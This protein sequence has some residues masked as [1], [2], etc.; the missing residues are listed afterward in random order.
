MPNSS[1]Y[2][3]VNGDLIEA[4][5]FDMWAG[6][7]S[8]RR[9]HF[10]CGNDSS[11]ALNAVPSVGSPR[12]LKHSLAF[13]KGGEDWCTVRDLALASC[14]LGFPGSSDGKASAC[15]VGDLG[16]I[17]GSGRFPGQGKWQPTPVHLPGEIPWTKEPSGLQS[18]GLQRVSHD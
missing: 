14:F 18:M 11:F 3:G 12:Q 7:E 17:P 5:A 4:R 16:S 13:R 8:G 1:L 10:D 9:Y 15:N 6:G 2:P